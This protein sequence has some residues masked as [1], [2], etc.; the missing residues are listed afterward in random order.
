M[1]PNPFNFPLNG[2]GCATGKCEN[3]GDGNQFGLSP[4]VAGSISGAGAGSYASPDSEK[5]SPCSGNC[6]NNEPPSCQG[7]NCNNSPN[8][9]DNPEPYDIPV[10][11]SD[12]QEHEPSGK[13]CQSGNCNSSPKH[14]TQDYPPKNNNENQSPT[15]YGSKKPDNPSSKPSNNDNSPET[16]N[17]APILSNNPDMRPNN[18]IPKTTQLAC[19]SGKCNGNSGAYPEGGQEYNPSTP[20][21]TNNAPPCSNGNCGGYGEKNTQPSK[22][23]ASPTYQTPTVQNI[24][25]PCANGN[26][27]SAPHKVPYQPTSNPTQYPANPSSQDEPVYTGGFGGPSGILTPNDY[28]AP[29]SSNLDQPNNNHQ[30]LPSPQH[31]PN[32][33]GNQHSHPN[34]NSLN[35]GKPVPHNSGV[36]PFPTDKPLSPFNTPQNPNSPSYSPPQ[37][38]KTPNSYAPN[39]SSPPVY[40]KPPNEKSPKPINNS[41]AYGKPTEPYNSDKSTLENTPPEKPYS[42]PPTNALP[43]PSLLLETPFKTAPQT[44]DND[45]LYSP[46]QPSSYNVPIIP[47]EDPYKSGPSPNNG[48]S[49]NPLTKKPVPSTLAPNTPTNKPEC[50]FGGCNQPEKKIPSNPSHPNS[51]EKTPK[52]PSIATS[53]IN[54]QLSSNPIDS[55]DDSPDFDVRYTASNCINGNC[56]EQS[57]SDDNSFKNQPN[58]EHPSYKPNSSSKPP[59]QN[60]NC[61]VINPKSPSGP[62]LPQSKFPS[63][64]NGKCKGSGFPSA[65]SEEDYNP[66]SPSGNTQPKSPLGCSNGKCGGS[67]PNSPA[68]DP[69]SPDSS[70]SNYYPQPSNP[71]CS[72]GKCGEIPSTPGSPTFNKYPLQPIPGCSNGQCNVGFP[73][74]PMGKP[75]NPD[76]VSLPAAKPNTPSFSPASNYPQP[77]KPGCTSGQCGGSYP[78]SSTGKP[79]FGC[80][81]GQCGGGFPNYPMAD[82][83]SPGSVLPSAETPYTPNISPSKYYPQ[84]SNPGCLNAQCGGNYPGSSTGKPYTPRGSVPNNY[85]PQSITGCANGQCGGSFPNFPMVEPFTPGSVSPPAGQPYTP[86][87]SPSN[88][89][90]PS[91]P[92]CSNGQCGNRFP[93]SPAGNPY[94]P[95]G[96]T[97]NNYPQSS[98]IGCSN[99]QCGGNSPYTPSSVAPDSYPPPVPSGCLHGKCGGIPGSPTGQPYTPGNPNSNDYGHK[100]PSDNSFPQT[101]PSE[102]P[103]GDCGKDSPTNEQYNPQTSS[104]SGT[105]KP[106]ANGKCAQSPKIP[107]Q[108]G[109]PVSPS[110]QGEPIYGGG[111]GGPSGLLKP[112]DYSALPP[113]NPT[114]SGN[115]IPSSSLPHYIPN[116][117]VH[118]NSQPLQP[119][120]EPHDSSP[121]NSGNGLQAAHPIP[122]PPHGANNLHFGAAGSISISGAG[123]Y[124]GGFGGPPGYLKPFDDDKGAKPKQSGAPL[125]AQPNHSGSSPAYGSGAFSAAGSYSGN[126]LKIDGPE[127]AGNPKESG[128]GGGCPNAGGFGASGSISGSLGLAKGGFDA[129]INGAAASAKSLAGALAATG[130]NAGSGSHG[131]SG[132]FASSSAVASS[133]SYK[134]GQFN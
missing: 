25:S 41:P 131:L 129:L 9:A 90:P 10:F 37:T 130:G 60:G 17:N 23:Y 28:T 31:L 6:L 57:S 120:P 19:G 36:T 109:H 128:C 12:K 85:P 46:N 1:G 79:N 5:P 92:G 88:Y 52:E 21:L 100:T 101:S 84:P 93:D 112:N 38:G 7:S 116:K 72:N 34:A 80:S 64:S 74:Y 96:P 105:A 99:G 30:A 20:S 35:P 2:G 111:F 42:S 83:Y 70:P 82:P 73:K 49:P 67:T 78:G 44:A 86:N 76:S 95:G 13:P 32:K 81:N 48:I 33:P 43:P 68:G 16:Y 62:P 121:Q 50:A 24:P 51:Q 104:S 8:S 123:A 54:V 56:V 63:C 97:L 125:N 69:Y 55:P 134:G 53:T 117:P 15:P 71:G 89:P 14:N 114:Q 91:K 40:S 108:T 133:G 66:S 119:S 77:S 106:C 22:P 39:P 18:Q 118:Q 103:N 65:P 26:C 102:C 110:S 59:C 27:K 75:Y 58:S 126:G 87:I 127:S 61:P 47:Q 3:G 124:T 98:I 115:T 4:N 29:I 107:N 45:D 113:S 11:I 132:S 94:T 122:Q